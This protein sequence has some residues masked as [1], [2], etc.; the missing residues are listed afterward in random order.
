[1][2]LQVTNEANLGGA[3]NASDGYHP[4]ANDALIRGVIAAKHELTLDHLRQLKIGFNWAY[5]ADASEQ[6]FWSYLHRHGGS[7]F[8]RALD[9]VGL[10]AYPGTWGPALATRLSLGDAVRRATVGALSALRHVYLPRARIPASVPIHV[11]ESGYPTGPGRSYGA[12]ADVLC[13]AVRAVVD[14]SATYNVTDYRW[15]DLRD[16]DSSSASFEAQY[17]LMTDAYTPKPAFAL[18]RRLVAAPNVTCSGMRL[19]P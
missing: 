6:S 4:G 3:P 12:Q 2:S 16:A 14:D 15:F 1:V 7:A 5:A 8:V 17:G 13:A 18:Y 10:D 11:T 19:H 9:W